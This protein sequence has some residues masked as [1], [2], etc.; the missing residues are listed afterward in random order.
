MAIIRKKQAVAESIDLGESADS[1]ATAVSEES[2]QELNLDT[3]GAEESGGPAGD[4][5]AGKIPEYAAE[6][7]P[8]DRSPAEND[9]SAGSSG[10]QTEAGGGD[11]TSAEESGGDLV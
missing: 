4:S 11:E 2:Q 6:K 8:A 5:D 3:S 1:A 10:E 9:S 7:S